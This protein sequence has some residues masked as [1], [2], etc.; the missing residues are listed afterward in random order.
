MVLRPKEFWKFFQM[1]IRPETEIFYDTEW[2]RMERNMKSN[3]YFS[4]IWRNFY[5]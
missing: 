3:N 1:W 4:S 2:N 5:N